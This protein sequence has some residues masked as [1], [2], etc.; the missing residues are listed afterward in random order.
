M[1]VVAA[2]VVWAM[3]YGIRRTDKIYRITAS[4]VLA[5]CATTPSMLVI[6]SGGHD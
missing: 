4:A 3:G 6:Q 5:I 2:A 1:Q